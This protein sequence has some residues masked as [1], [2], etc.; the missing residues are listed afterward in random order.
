MANE[1]TTTTLATLLGIATREANSILVDPNIAGVN[2]FDYITVDTSKSAMKFPVI[3]EIAG[4]TPSEGAN[5]T[6]VEVTSTGPTVT[7]VRNGTSVVLTREMVERGAEQAM[8]NL[9][10]QIGKT[11]LAL[12]NQAV[13]AL[14]DGFVGNTVGTTNVDI[15]EQNIIDGIAMLK[16]AGAPGQYYLAVT[17]HVMEDLVGLYKS[18]TSVVAAGIREEINNTGRVSRLFGAQVLEIGNLASG[19]SAGQRDGAD[20]KCGLF[21]RSTIGAVVS[22]PISIEIEWRP[23]S[24]SWL[25]AGTTYF[26]VGEINDLWGVEVLVD[27]KD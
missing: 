20:A 13:W 11:C 1:S 7:P 23:A 14:F 8:A 12:Q 24:Q 2:L 18:S 4:E 10:A 9:G 25:L 16:A 26:G 15:T 27:N 3:P 19:T 21:T 17:P 5:Y 22:S 6:V